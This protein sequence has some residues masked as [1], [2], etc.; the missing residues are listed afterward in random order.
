M[1][2]RLVS[3]SVSKGDWTS[4]QTECRTNLGERRT[5]STST[6][7]DVDVNVDVNVVV[8]GSPVRLEL[9]VVNADG[10]SMVGAMICA[11]LSKAVPVIPLI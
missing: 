5:R 8:V 6:V 3:V 2:G 7:V 4:Q 1:G 9:R 11:D 10:V